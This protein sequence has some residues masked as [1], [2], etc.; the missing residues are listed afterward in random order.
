MDFADR[1]SP[2]D[3]VKNATFT[4]PRCLSLNLCVNLLNFCVN[5]DCRG[6]KKSPVGGVIFLM[7][8][9]RRC[10][11][12]GRMMP[13]PAFPPISHDYPGS[14]DKGV[15]RFQRREAAEIPIHRPE[16]PDPAHEAAGC[17]SGIVNQG[18]AHASVDRQLSQLVQNSGGIA[19]DSQAG[20]FPP[21]PDLFD[22]LFRS[23]WFF[24]QFRMGDDSVE[25]DE[26]VQTRRP[27]SRGFRKMADHFFRF[28]MERGFALMRMHQQIG[29]HRDHHPWK[30][31]SRASLIAR[32]IASLE[33]AVPSPACP[34]DASRN[35]KEAAGT[36]IARSTA[37]IT[38]VR[39]VIF[40][41]ASNGLTRLSKSSGT[42]TVVLI[43]KY[44][45]P[46]MQASKA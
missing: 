42:S 35:R 41:S 37:S 31:G 38:S 2:Q 25:L 22:C 34:A 29:I 12:S 1:T 30:E 46:E 13:G 44:I 18:P 24:P 4:I 36:S 33:T 3:S 5:L 43:C 17:D 10:M 14:G 16:F 9:S 26:T 15:S 11:A 39:K 40:L 20:R 7:R 8:S 19:Q 23:G 21:C 27:R 28:F 6:R 32:L 45:K